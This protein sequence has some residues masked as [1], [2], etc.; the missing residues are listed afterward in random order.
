MNFKKS[1]WVVLASMLFATPVMG[2]EIEG[3]FSYEYFTETIIDEKTDEK[4]NLVNNANKYVGT[5]YLWGGTTTK[6]FDCSGFVQRV[7]K[8]TG[9]AIPRSSKEMSIFGVLTT[10]PDLKVGDLLFFDTTDSIP[11]TINT[12]D[13]SLQYGHDVEAGVKKN[14]VSHVGIYIGN[15]EMI[16]SGDSGVKVVNLNSSYYKNRF[17]FA[18]RVF[19]Q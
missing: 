12:K 15:D 18:R 14:R 8:D 17:L 3:K 16:H 6:G 7:Y 10:R 11:Y 1:I 5:P 2:Q 9:Y 4:I 19:S 13:T